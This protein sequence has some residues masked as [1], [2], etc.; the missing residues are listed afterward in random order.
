MANCGALEGA[1]TTAL[2]G[3]PAAAVGGE[4]I[5][6]RRELDLG[7]ARRSPDDVHRLANRFEPNGTHLECVCSEWQLA[8]RK[9]AI[10]VGELF[11]PRSPERHTSAG[12]CAT[13]R[14]DH[15]SP[16]ATGTS[17]QVD[18]RRRV[19][20]NRDAGERGNEDVAVQK[21]GGRNGQL[22]HAAAVARAHALKD[23][24]RADRKPTHGK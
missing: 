2:L 13:G 14:S 8:Q 20:R 4:Q 11:D 16:D 3:V 6:G 24:G 12:H 19:R 7:C 17:Q 5:D 9:G 21:A 1:T 18:R 10:G 22:E 15:A 23:D